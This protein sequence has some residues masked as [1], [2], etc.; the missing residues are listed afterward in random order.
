M[1]VA[2]VGNSYTFFNDMPGM[3]AKLSG[4]A[5]ID[6]AQESVTKGGSSIHGHADQSSKL[7]K[8]TLQLLQDAS[9][10]DFVVLQDESQTPGG[11]RDTDEGLDA[12]EGRRLSIDALSSFYAPL[13]SAG[14]ATAVLY[15]TWGRHD[16][17]EDNAECC[18]YTDF[19]SMNA[20]TEQGYQLYAQALSPVPVLTAPCGRGFE[21]VHNRS[22]EDPLEATSL[23]SCLYHHGLSLSRNCKLDFFG[24]GGHPSVLGTYLISCVLFG[25]IHGRSPIGLLFVPDGI[26]TEDAATVQQLAHQAVFDISRGGQ[27]V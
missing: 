17:D 23:F 27:L 16:A 5:G 25:T 7:G 10:W 26:S 12:G 1:R 18:G 8:Q 2:F 11:G 3:F 24:T 20:L 9:G 14:N 22:Q 19:L 13:L 6:V 4:S 21:L 15:S